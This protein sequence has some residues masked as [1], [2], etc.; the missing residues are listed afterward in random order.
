MVDDMPSRPESMLT[1]L[2]NPY[3]P[4]S[5][6]DE[7]FAWDE[8]AGYHSSGLLARVVRTSDDLSEADQHRAIQDAIDEIVKEN[9][10][11]VSIKVLKGEKRGEV[12]AA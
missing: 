11:G 7:W 4:W 12:Q 10:L 6:W 2:D 9:V 3:D 5:Q 1:T 8:A